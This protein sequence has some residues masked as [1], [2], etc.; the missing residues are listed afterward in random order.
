MDAPA[1]QMT[2]LFDEG[3]VDI[4]P[5]NQNDFENHFLISLTS[6]GASFPVAVEKNGDVWRTRPDRPSQA[7]FADCKYKASGDEETQYGGVPANFLRKL[8]T[9]WQDAGFPNYMTNN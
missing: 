1:K 7:A 9:A 5:V 8:A 4:L 6:D 3:W 2:I